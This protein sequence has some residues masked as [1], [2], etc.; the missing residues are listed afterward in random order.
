[1]YA[2]IGIALISVV[3]VAATHR[4]TKEG[5]KKFESLKK[6]WERSVEDQFK[7][8]KKHND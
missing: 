2:A 6:K 5:E 1:M 8:K 4:G 7:K 3:I